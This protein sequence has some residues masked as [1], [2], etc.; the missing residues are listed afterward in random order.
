MH[1]KVDNFYE[2][3][4]M[5]FGKQHNVYILSHMHEDHLRGLSGM[6]HEP[7]LGWNYGPIY[8]SDMTHRMMLL[9]FPHLEPYMIPI[10]Q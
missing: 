9:R 3:K 4:N 1:I 10:K 8:L 7:I 2:I 6:S 5:R